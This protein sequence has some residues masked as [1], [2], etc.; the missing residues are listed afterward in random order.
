MDIKIEQLNVEQAGVGAVRLSARLSCNRNGQTWISN[1]SA[2]GANRAEAVDH[3]LK[4]NKV[5][6]WMASQL[7]AALANLG[8]EAIGLPKEQKPSGQA[9]P[10]GQDSSSSRLT[11]KEIQKPQTSIPSPTSIQPA[12]PIAKEAPKKQP[13]T[14][15]KTPGGTIL[16]SLSSEHDQPKAVVTE[17]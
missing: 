6:A 1:V 13:K 10:E 4:D 11:E 2:Q 3:L 7:K 12:P 14:G 5:R 17:F 9:A 8:Q 15:S 16:E